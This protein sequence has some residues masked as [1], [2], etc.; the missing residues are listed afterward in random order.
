MTWSMNTY[1]I[2]CSS[3]TLGGDAEGGGVVGWGGVGVAVV[4]LGL[5]QEAGSRSRSVGLASC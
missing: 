4:V 5:K 2:F 1:C 3:N